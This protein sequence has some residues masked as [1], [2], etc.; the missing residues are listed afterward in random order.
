LIQPVVLEVFSIAEAEQIDIEVTEL[1]QT[2]SN[3]IKATAGNYSSKNRDIY[4]G[5]ETEIQYINGYLI[6]KAQQHN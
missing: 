5:S 1:Q 3:V 4:Y 2:V 6:K